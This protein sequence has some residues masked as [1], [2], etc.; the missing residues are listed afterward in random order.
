VR[1]KSVYL[2]RF[3]IFL[4][5]E[6]NSYVEKSNEVPASPSTAINELSFNFFK[7]FS[8]RTATCP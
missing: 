1:L 6:N 2:K 7:Q 8:R 5:T 3:A 4:S